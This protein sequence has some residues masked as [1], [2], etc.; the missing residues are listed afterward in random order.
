[1]KEKLSA[2]EYVIRYPG[3]FARRHAFIL[4][5]CQGTSITEKDANPAILAYN[6][7]TAANK[8]LELTEEG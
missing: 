1:M 6:I 5:L 4:A 8:L 2:R 7:Y 3:R